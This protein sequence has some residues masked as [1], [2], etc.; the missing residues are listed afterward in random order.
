VTAA[1]PRCV[2]VSHGIFSPVESHL[3]KSL[4]GRE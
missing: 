2:I 3:G 4:N 1:S